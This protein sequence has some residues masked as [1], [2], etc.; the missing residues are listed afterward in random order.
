MTWFTGLFSYLIIWWLV[1][2]IVLPWGNRPPEHPG[3][4]HIPSAPE[5]PRL[6]IKFAATTA[7][8]AIV[9]LGVYGVIE[10]GWIKIRE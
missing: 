6:L 3:P 1:L 7:I 5:K 10:S 9:F 2:F 8:A 4:G